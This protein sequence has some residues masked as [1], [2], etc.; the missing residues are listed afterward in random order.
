MLLLDYFPVILY[1]IVLAPYKLLIWNIIEPGHY[2]YA[3]N[4]ITW[5][6]ERRLGAQGQLWLHEIL[7]QKKKDLNQN[8]P[9]E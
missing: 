4:S 2:V 9:K 3:Y 8:Q 5:M 1:K 6:R 7:S